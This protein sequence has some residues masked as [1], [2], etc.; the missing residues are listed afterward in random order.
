LQGWPEDVAY[1]A[2]T[3]VM[4]ALFVDLVRTGRRLDA[5]DR[6]R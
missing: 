5:I 2:L 6:S 3:F 1:V 4:V